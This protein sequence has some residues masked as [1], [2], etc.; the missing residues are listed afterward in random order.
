VKR[1]QLKGTLPVLAL[2]ALAVLASAVGCAKKSPLEQMIENRSR[3]TAELNESGFI[4]EET[5]IVA[6]VPEGDVELE[7]EAPAEGEGEGEAEGEGEMLEPEPV[8]VDQK[9]HLDIL[10]RHDSYEKLPGITV[11]ISMVDAGLN[12]KGHWR[13]WLDT[14][15]IER[16]NL[17]QFSHTLENVGYVEGD[18]F[19][20]EVR[21]PIPEGERGDYKEF[22]DFG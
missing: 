13:V 7:G 19:S 6:A 2:A 4:L 3:Y 11:D 15:N 21:H 14:S 10:V 5:P 17:T 20:V 9:V 8:Q 16:A 1:I 18:A 22:A 12:E